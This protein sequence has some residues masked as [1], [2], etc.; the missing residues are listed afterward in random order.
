MINPL[1]KMTLAW[2][3]WAR[4]KVAKE[5]EWEKAARDAAMGDVMMLTIE[6][7]RCRH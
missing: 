5:A 2:W 7:C 3:V 6:Q 4:W 1:N